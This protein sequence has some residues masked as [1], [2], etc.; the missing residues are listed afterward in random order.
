MR[1]ICPIILSPK[2]L[3]TSLE[4]KIIAV[5][6]IPRP[7]SHV[8]HVS[9]DPL[10]HFI[11]IC[12][13]S[14]PLWEFLLWLSGL[15]TP[16]VSMRIWVQ[17]LTLLS[18]LRIRHCRKHRLQ[19]RLGSSVAMAVVQAGS[20]SPDSWEIPYAAGMALKRKEVS[21]SERPALIIPPKITHIPYHSLSF[22]CLY[23]S[24]QEKY[25]GIILFIFLYVVQF[26]P[27][28]AEPQESKDLV[29]FTDGYSGPTTVLS[30]CL[31]NV[32]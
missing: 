6:A 4:Y 25:T 1:F 15:R 7:G 32:E 22:I 5:A 12:T 20:C 26:S 30:R 2:D 11:Q 24:P 16:L 17:S 14:L 8:T 21:H 3:Y 18:G 27:S 28:E 23:F 10:P 9:P 13:Q 29:M 31:M 19:M